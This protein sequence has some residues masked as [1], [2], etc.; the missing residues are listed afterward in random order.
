MSNDEFW[1]D[2]F[3]TDDLDEANKLISELEE[4]NATLQTQHAELKEAA[5]GLFNTLGDV[6]N[7]LHHN[8]D[9]LYGDDCKG[10]GKLT[11]RF[12]RQI[13]EI[14]TSL[15]AFNAKVGK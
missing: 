15:A 7:Y 10:D 9:N 12:K 4:Q 2:K 13:L 14:E 11:A 5:R 3:A 6:L 8:T 1:K